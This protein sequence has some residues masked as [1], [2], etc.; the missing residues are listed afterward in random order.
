MS[1]EKKQP[2]PP[3]PEQVR[4]CAQALLYG[5]SSRNRV[6][7]LRNMLAWFLLP[8]LP[9]GEDVTVELVSALIQ[10]AIETRLDLEDMV[11][12]VE[13]DT[14]SGHDSKGDS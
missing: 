2:D 3:S 8:M 9:E 6:E 12:E 14:E 10:A 5:A 4:I 13:G 1:E 7:S 11:E